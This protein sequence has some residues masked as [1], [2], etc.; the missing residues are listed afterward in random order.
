MADLRDDLAHVLRRTTFGPFPGGIDAAADQVTSARELVERQLAAAPVPFEPWAVVDGVREVVDVDVADAPQA[1][2][3]EAERRRIARIMAFRPW[4]VRRMASDEAG[5]HEKMMWFWHGHFTTSSDKVD[6]TT[7]CWRQLR[8]LHRH[9]T[10]N[11]GDLAKAM[12]VD[13]AMLKY[14]DGASSV[15]QEPNENYGREFLELFTLGLGHFDQRDVVAASKVFA[16][17]TVTNPEQEVRRVDANTLREPVRA[18]GVR[19]RFSP[20][21]LIDVVLEQDACAPFV[22]SKLWRSFVGGEPDAGLVGRWADRF[23]RS[24][25]EILPLLEDMLSSEAFSVARFGRARTPV[26]WYCTAIRATGDADRDSNMDLYRLGQSPYRPPSVAGWPDVWLSPTQSHARALLLGRFAFP[27]VAAWSGLPTAELV[28][29][30]G[31]RCGVPAWSDDSA[32]ALADLA[33]RVDAGR[34]RAAATLA[35]ALMTPELTLA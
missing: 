35:A 9:A 16:G 29:R 33:D 23:R 27:D 30:V 21:E 15:A 20:D 13:G 25:Y 14:L 3:S 6:D 31:S 32:T 5:L 28:D 18:F 2:G 10:G 26:E 17:Y 8:T 34:S 19:R 11:F 1:E 22:V 12:T 7:L 24:G 4:W